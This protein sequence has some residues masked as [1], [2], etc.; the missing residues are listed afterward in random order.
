M[1]TGMTQR[2]RRTLAAVTF[3][4]VLAW[5]V[6]CGPRYTDYSAFI[7]EP[8]PIVTATEYRV[9]PPDGLTFNSKRVREINGLT[10]VIR[11]DGKVSLPL[12]GSV[13]V[14]GKTTEQISAELE[15]LA[16]RYYEDADVMVRVS[17]FASKRIFVFGQVGTAGPYPYN[18][19]NTVLDTLARAQP[20]FLAD[21]TRIQVLRPNRQGELIRR[22]TVNLDDM[23][24]KGDTTLD[25]V[26]E[27]GDIVYVPPHAFATVGLAMQTLLLPIRPAAEVV[28]G[29]SSIQTS[30]E[31]YGE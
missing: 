27:E 14:A 18:G 22:M 30:A 1:H 13:F 11:P 19:A 4:A 2:R 26:L 16:A 21:V 25:A 8:K 12:L 17:T 28:N 23:V 7:R 31:T 24:K 6:G 9:A 3:A 20:T 10:M 15:S 29:P 5:P